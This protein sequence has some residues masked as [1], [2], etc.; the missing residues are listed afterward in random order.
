MESNVSKLLSMLQGSDRN[1]TDT[2][3]QRKV[4]HEFS[5]PQNTRTH[6]NTH[7]RERT[8]KR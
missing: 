3:A 8:H 2:D 7:E 1:M 4:T 5:R 6:D